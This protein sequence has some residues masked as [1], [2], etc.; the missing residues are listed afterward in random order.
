MIRLFV[1]LELPDSVRSDLA[2]ICSGV[3]GARW[4]APDNLHLTLRFIGNVE[5]T[6]LGDIDLALSKLRAPAFD[7]VIQGVDQFCKG[8]RPTMLWAG[9]PRNPALT[10]LQG[11]VERAIQRA[12]LEPEGR[13]FTP[14]VTLARLKD[15]NASRVRTFITANSLFRSAPIPVERI[16]LFSSFLARS[17]AIYRAEAEYALQASEAVPG[18]ASALQH[19]PHGFGA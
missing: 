7:L 6:V 4:V 11:R 2:A 12:G 10:H 5:D 3:P 13:K 8:R 15:A 16:T 9:V 18:G 19:G 1:G 14:H 17:G